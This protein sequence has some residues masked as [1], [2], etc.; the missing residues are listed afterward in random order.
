[1]L[2]ETGRRRLLLVAA[3]LAAAALLWLAGRGADWSQAWALVRAAHGGWLAVAVL[4][5]LAILLLW[6]ALWRGLAGAARPS[7]RTMLA[8]VAIASAV[9]NTVPMLAGHATAVVLLTQ[10]AG[11][12]MPA[13]LSL[14][15]MDQ[16]GEGVSK[17]ALFASAA[18]LAPLPA[19]MRAGIASV[20]VVVG[21]L[22]AVLLVLAHRAPAQLPR[23]PFVGAGLASLGGHLAPLRRPRA[24]AR[25][26]ALALA[27]KGAEALAIVLVLRAFGSPAPA[28]ASPVV[29]SAVNL[30]TMLPIA[31]ANLGA[32]EA[33]ASATFQGLGLAPETALA[34]AIVQHACFL[35]PAVGAGVLVLLV[36]RRR[37][38]AAT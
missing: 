32:Y 20:A 27:M 6:A 24:A 35:L 1:M 38:R 13:A 31:P 28:S 23:I 25:A 36:P 10:R 12:A 19:W 37:A 18:W 30:A 29:L 15:A 34:V 33:A 5:N 16:L 4:A 14:L 3:W 8:I 17:L 21:L 2:A 22:L 7:Y 26:L 11:L 9:M